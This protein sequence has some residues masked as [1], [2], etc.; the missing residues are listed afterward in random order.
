[1]ARQ[2][3]L[4]CLSNKPYLTGAGFRT[5]GELGNLTVG[6]TYKGLREGDWWRVWDN[7]D[8]DY[9]YPLKMFEMAVHPE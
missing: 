9:L 5:D 7:L 4:I 1:M 2:V 3:D 8:E 6:K